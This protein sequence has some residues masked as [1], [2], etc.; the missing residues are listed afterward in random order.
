MTILSASSRN[1]RCNT[2][3]SS[4]GARIQ[5]S[6]SSAVVRITGIA[7][8]WLGSTN[9]VER[10]RHEAVDEMVRW[11]RAA[12][13]GARPT[14][15]VRIA[16]VKLMTAAPRTSRCINRGFGHAKVSPSEA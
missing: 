4:H 8:G 9:C 1:G 3:A 5:T 2:F 13:A 12:D 14:P 15:L 10:R 16:Y 7:F 11:S 6:C